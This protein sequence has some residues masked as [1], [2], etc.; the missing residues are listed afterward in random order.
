MQ[1]LCLSFPATG[2]VFEKKIKNNLL[3][4]LTCGLLFLLFLMTQ[5]N[6]ISAN[7]L[8]GGRILCTWGKSFEKGL[9]VE[10]VRRLNLEFGGMRNMAF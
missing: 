7:V 3:F 4:F 6:S 8:L 10:R 2:R 9:L 5:L 1:R